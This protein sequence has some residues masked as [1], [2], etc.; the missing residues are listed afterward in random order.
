MLN[1]VILIGRLTARPE[2]R[3][4]GDSLLTRGRIA[5]SRRF[6][7]RDGNWDGETLFISFSVWGEKG[8]RFAEKANKGDLVLV[9]GRLKG[10]EWT[11]ESGKRRSAVEVAAER[12]GVISKKLSS[13]GNGAEEFDLEEVEEIDLEDY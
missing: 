5:V 8:S 2:T 12:L 7:R 3:E 13:N 9:E 1:R 4:V 6:R 11:D 10:I